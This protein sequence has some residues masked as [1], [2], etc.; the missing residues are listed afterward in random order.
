MNTAHKIL[1]Y[2][3]KGLL[4]FIDITDQV[5][6]FLKESGVQNGFVNIQTLHTTA[7]IIL[8]ENEPLLIE[9]FK[10]HLKE[11]A[12]LGLPYNHDDFSKRTVNLCDDECINGH[13]HCKAIHLPVNITLNLI[14]GELQ[15]GQWQRIMFLELDTPRKRKVQILVM[16]E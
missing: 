14:N 15:L 10:N 6:A 8:N 11:I 9:D 12:P 3:T 4:E 1:E 5:K 7:A 2:Q 16:G 13:S